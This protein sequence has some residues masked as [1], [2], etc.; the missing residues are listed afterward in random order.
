MLA[1]YSLY[2]LGT[3][4]RED[5]QTTEARIFFQRLLA[6]Y[7]DSIWASHAQLE[8]AKLALAEQDWSTAHGTL[9]YYII[10][11]DSAPT[12]RSDARARPDA[13]GKATTATPTTSI[14]NSD[15]SLHSQASGKPQKKTSR[16][17]GWPLRPNLA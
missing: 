15:A 11:V 12:T 5:G 6:E 7:P 10:A 9:N 1:D 3:I 17:S 8:L 16:N 4:N 2:Y 13:K 14:K